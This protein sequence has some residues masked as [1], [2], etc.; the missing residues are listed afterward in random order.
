MRDLCTDLYE[1]RVYD[2]VLKALKAPADGPFRLVGDRGKSWSMRSWPE[3]VKS[4]RCCSIYPRASSSPAVAMAD[5]VPS[6]S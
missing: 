5:Q 6:T 1:N 3:K 4:V 2:G